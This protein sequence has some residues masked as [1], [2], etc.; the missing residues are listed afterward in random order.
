[1]KANGRKIPFILAGKDPDHDDK[2]RADSHSRIGVAVREQVEIE[3]CTGNR[4]AGIY[5]FSKD[6]RCPSGKD[7][8]EDTASHPGRN[9]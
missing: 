4:G 3:N 5:V 1:M 9:T 7:V 8:S 6:S 2:G